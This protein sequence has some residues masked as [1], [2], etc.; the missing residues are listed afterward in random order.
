MI[1]I[2]HSNVPP[3]PKANA[4]VVHTTFGAGKVLTVG[5]DALGHAVTIDFDK[6]GKKALVWNFAHAKITPE[7][8]PIAG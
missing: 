5:K 1:I 7:P 2:D 6:Y 8:V 4:R 3:P